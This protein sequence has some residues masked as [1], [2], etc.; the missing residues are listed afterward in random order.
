MSNQNC[1]KMEKC[2]IFQKDI[3]YSEKMGQTYRNL[4]CSIPEKFITC[5]RYI[6]SEKTGLKIPENIMPN[7]MLSDDEIIKIV[8]KLK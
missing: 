4:Y 2:P 8:K 5:K 6:V 3:L 1:P 7:S